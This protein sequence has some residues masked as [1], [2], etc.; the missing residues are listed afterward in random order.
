M[1]V[2]RQQRLLK[3]LGC[4]IFLAFNQQLRPISA[5]TGPIISCVLCCLRSVGD[6]MGHGIKEMGSLTL[7]IHPW[8]SPQWQAGCSHGV[9][10]CCS[11]HAPWG[12][13]GTPHNRRDHHAPCPQHA[14]GC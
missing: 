6:A 11:G 1:N 13:V 3:H 10:T 9:S 7:T 5:C 14:C 2:A 4:N 12:H 8:S